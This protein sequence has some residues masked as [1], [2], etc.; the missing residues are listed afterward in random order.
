MDDGGWNRTVARFAAAALLLTALAGCATREHIP[1]YPAMSDE[2][3]LRTLARRAAAI[4]DVSGSGT[5][6]LT[7]PDGNSVRMDVAVVMQRPGM[8]RMR[9]WKF[10]RAVF[11]LTV[12][13]DG[14]FLVAPDEA[15]GGRGVGAGEKIRKAGIGAGKFARA[16]G[17]LFGGDFFARPGVR[18]IKETPF[19]VE[20][21]VS[22]E[23]VRCEVDRRTLT[24]RV[25]RVLDEGGTERF[26][27][28]LSKYVDHGGGLV[29]PHRMLATSAQGKVEVALREV[30]VNAGVAAGAFKPPAR[31][32]K[33]P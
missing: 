32:E 9:A 19:T 23:R 16:V 21:E 29:Y 20:A 15:G 27:L 24:P 28:E 2:A 13:A 18:V 10:S 17:V 14:V 5:V 31:A 11:D 8:V 6:T 30:D 22:G 25:Y 3:A 12:N 7:R 26:R 33:L 4:H 1:T